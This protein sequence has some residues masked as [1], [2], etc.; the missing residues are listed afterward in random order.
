MIGIENLNSGL[1]HVISGI[2]I[3]IGSAV[4][5][6]PSLHA[7]PCYSTGEAPEVIMID[8]FNRKFGLEESIQ[9]RNSIRRC[10]LE[11]S[12]NIRSEAITSISPRDLKVMFDLYDDSF[13]GSQFKN[14]YPGK[15]KLSLS[16]RMTKSAGSTVCPKNIAELKPENLVLEIKI[17]VDFLFNY[18]VLEGEKAVCGMQTSDSLQALQLVFEHELCHVIEYIS[19]HESNCSGDRFKSLANNLFGHTDSHHNL[20]TYRQIARQKF[21]LNLGDV[22]SFTCKGKRLKGIIYNIQKRATVFVPDQGGSFVDKQGKTYS[23]Y[24]VPLNLLERDDGR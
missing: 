7:A 11:E 19:F 15:I 5:I 17:G 22:V 13:F 2:I 21:V 16:R 6:I 23:K 24:Y 14:G 8:L 12:P 20:P 18:G 1:I 4:F 9:K 10:L 3:K